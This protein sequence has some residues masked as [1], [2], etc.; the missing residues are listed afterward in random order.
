MKPMT[1]MRKAASLVLIVT[2]L[3]AAAM[4]AGVANAGTPGDDLKQ[5]EYQYYFRGKYQ[6]AI[7]A[8]QTYLARVDLSRADATRA[9]E[10]LAASYVLGGAPVMGKEVFAQIIVAD[11]S[12]KG[13]DPTVFKLDVMN[14][15][16]QARSE[17]A[18]LAIQ[19]A[20]STSTAARPAEAIEGQ[21][22]E[23]TGKPIYKKWWFY[24]GAAAVLL[25]VGAAASGGD[26]SGGGGAPTGTL[27]VGVTTP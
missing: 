8:L 9:R 12:Y 5:I 10:F 19:Q 14:A 2:L 24:A 27:V 16:G 26:D 17:Y 25:A 11:P 6:Q 4:P 3:A 21:V 1:D 15:Y 7:E 13:P 23:E 22:A 20:P 18:A